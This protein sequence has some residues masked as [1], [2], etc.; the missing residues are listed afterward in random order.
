MTAADHETRLMTGESDIEGIISQYFKVR[1][2]MSM[3]VR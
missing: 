1:N 2:F 3:V